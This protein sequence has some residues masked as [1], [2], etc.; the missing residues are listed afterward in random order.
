MTNVLLQFLSLPREDTKRFEILNLI[1]SIL[2][3]T[4]EQRQRAGLARSTGLGAT[5]G[6]GGVKRSSSNPLLSDYPMSPG[7]DRK[8]VRPYLY[9]QAFLSLCF[10]LAL[11]DILAGEFCFTTFSVCYEGGAYGRV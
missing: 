4:E 3:W 10:H 8:E 11:N 6:S 2:E 1:A 9:S 5:T 7:L